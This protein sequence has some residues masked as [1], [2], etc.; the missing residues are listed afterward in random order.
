MRLL[1]RCSANK[2]LERLFSVNNFHLSNDECPLREGDADYG[3]GYSRTSQSTT[4]LH[5]V[6]V[7]HLAE[8]NR[9]DSSD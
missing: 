1:H 9:I 6:M 8:Q 4:V 3:N 2:L 5:D 7:T